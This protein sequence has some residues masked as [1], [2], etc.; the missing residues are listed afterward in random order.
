MLSRGLV[1]IMSEQMAG[2]KQR[3]GAQVSGHLSDGSGRPHKCNPITTP[4]EAR[5]RIG[6]HSTGNLPD[7]DAQGLHHDIP[8]HR[9]DVAGAV[10]PSVV[11]PNSQRP[12]VSHMMRPPTSYSGPPVW[13]WVPSTSQPPFPP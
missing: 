1:C 13:P 2:N 11:G 8:T 12:P 7:H 9:S 3:R 10:T 6:R 4:S 5:T